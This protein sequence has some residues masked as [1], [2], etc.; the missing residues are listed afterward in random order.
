MEVLFSS[1]IVAN[2]AVLAAEC[3][4]K[5]FGSAHKIDYRD[6]SRPADE[7]IAGGGAPL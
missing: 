1:C 4:C 2:A 3:E 5:G 7:V 6:K